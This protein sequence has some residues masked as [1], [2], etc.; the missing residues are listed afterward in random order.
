LRVEGCR[1]EAVDAAEASELVLVGKELS[2]DRLDKGCV[3]SR[4]VPDGAPDLL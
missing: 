3:L 2:L 1:D 4:L